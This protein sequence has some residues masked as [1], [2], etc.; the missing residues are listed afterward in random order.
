MT[1]RTPFLMLAALLAALMVVGCAND[2]KVRHT[3]AVTNMTRITSRATP[4]LMPD[5]SPDGQ[6]VAFV[7][8]TKSEE[9]R[10]NNFDIWMME[11][12]NKLGQYMRAT[13]NEC[14][15]YSP[16]WGP[17][18]KVIIFDSHRTRRSSI[19]EMPADG[20]GGS[21]QVTGEDVYTDY[22][23]PDISIHG[24][25]CYVAL[26]ERQPFASSILDVLIFPFSLVGGAVEFMWSNWIT[27]LPVLDV[28]R[29]EGRFIEDH[30]I[31]TRSYNGG[32]ARELC[33]GVNPKWSPDGSTI[34][35]ASKGTKTD[36]DIWTIE[37]NGANLRQLTS[38]PAQDIQP[39]WSSD[40]K[41]LAFSSNRGASWFE[42]TFGDQNYDIWVMNAHGGGLIQLTN[43]SK[44]EG[45]PSW[46]SDGDIYFHSY[47]GFFLKNW[48]IWRM[49]PSL[50]GPEPQ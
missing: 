9:G 43:Y 33:V 14:D 12:Q 36:F 13:D 31:W 7:G 5:A 34:V 28:A 48:D 27:G 26:P 1:A 40:G 8:L 15:D 44:F 17:N 38:H 11:P 19:W 6:K 37:K 41:R 21:R 47:G 45:C 23:S 29:V 39:C 3:T 32:N 30:Y 16:A 24:D 10:H 50:P 49:T 18:G 2:Y 46:S 25:F 22:V 4:E 20:I 35:F 42:R